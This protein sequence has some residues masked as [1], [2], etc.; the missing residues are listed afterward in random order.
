[1]RHLR[2]RNVTS[3]QISSGGAPWIEGRRRRN[4]YWTVNTSVELPRRTVKANAVAPF[5]A[6]RS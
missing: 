4:S 5:T 6:W 1:M 3:Y 2:S